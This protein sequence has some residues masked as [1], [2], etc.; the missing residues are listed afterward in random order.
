MSEEP[1]KGVEIKT[2][3]KTIMDELHDYWNGHLHNHLA[4]TIN[5]RTLKQMG[6]KDVWNYKQIATSGA[7]PVM[8]PVL[9]K[10]ILPEVQREHDRNLRVLKV[11]AELIEREE[12]K[13]SVTSTAYDFD[14]DD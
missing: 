7:K 14:F 4:N 1:K 6:E 5:L 2:Y 13:S 3:R 10:D 9:A 8:N 12:S 11:I